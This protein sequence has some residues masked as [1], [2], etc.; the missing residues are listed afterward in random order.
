MKFMN[1]RAFF[2]GLL[3]LPFIRHLPK[4]KSKAQVFNAKFSG[5][6]HVFKTIHFKNWGNVTTF[7]VNQKR[8]EVRGLM[9]AL[10]PDSN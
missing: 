1:R 4:P 6:C 7:G 9:A 3:V 8:I 5:S 2:M 10:N